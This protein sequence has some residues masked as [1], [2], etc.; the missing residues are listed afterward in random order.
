MKEKWNHSK[1]TKNIIKN[2]NNENNNLNILKN[3]MNIN[4]IRRKLK[5]LK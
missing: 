5:Y 3:K 4:K 2:I 1:L